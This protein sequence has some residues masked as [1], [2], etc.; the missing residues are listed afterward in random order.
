MD[1]P[2]R[3][4]V[5]WLFSLARIKGMLPDALA[6]RYGRHY[7]EAAPEVKLKTGRRVPVP[8]RIRTGVPR[9]VAT[10]FDMPAR[11]HKMPPR[12]KRFPW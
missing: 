9:T 2:A 4:L 11:L 3:C 12:P 5:A 10:R 1:H 8:G 6:E 7:P